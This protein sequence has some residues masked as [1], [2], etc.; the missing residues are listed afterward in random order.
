V[1][2]LWGRYAA[3][4]AASLDERWEDASELAP[5]LLDEAESCSEMRAAWRLAAV[6]ARSMR[7]LGRADEAEG[8]RARGEAILRPIIDSIPDE[9]RAGFAAKPAVQE[10]LAVP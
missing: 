1:W 7:A 8:F 2:G 9:L 6:A 3:A 10:L 4:L 5:A